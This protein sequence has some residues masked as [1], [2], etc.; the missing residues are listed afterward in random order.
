MPK[1]D[2]IAVQALGFI[3]ADP[4]RLD[5]FLTATGLSPATLRTAAGEPGFFRQVLDFLMQNESDLVEFAA[6]S[7]MDPA[8]IVRLAG[9]GE[10]G[11]AW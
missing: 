5:R 9:G 11:G 6:N 3:A 7:G 10:Q 1:H 8:R 4:A 2:E